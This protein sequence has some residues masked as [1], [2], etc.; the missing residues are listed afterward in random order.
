MPSNR[1]PDLVGYLW[2]CLDEDEH[3][4]VAEEVAADPQL[5]AELE[6]LRHRLEPLAWDREPDAAPP[7]LAVDTLARVAEFACRD[8]KLPAAPPVTRPAGTERPWRRRIDVAVAAS[9]ILTS[10]A[11]LLPTIFSIREQ[12]QRLACQDNLRTI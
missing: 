11:L 2:N 12:M 7:G 8:R 1:M 5:Q 3:R 4:R 6:S 9:V 10:L